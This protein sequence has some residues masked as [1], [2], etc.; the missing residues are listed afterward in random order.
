[1]SYN[2]DATTNQSESFDF[3]LGGHQYNFRYPTT[4]EALALGKMR[5]PNGSQD[6]DSQLHT[7]Y[8]FVTPISEGA[9]GIEEALKDM[10]I[11]FFNAFK[12]MA[13]TEMGLQS[14]KAA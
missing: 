11:K 4:E 9:P 3:K 5:L 6:A 12:D 1:M 7:I 8:A 14:A 10:N 2:L 13:M